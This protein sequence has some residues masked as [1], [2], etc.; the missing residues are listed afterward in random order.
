MK[1]CSCGCKGLVPVEMLLE[2]CQ[3]K[4]K[5]LDGLSKEATLCEDHCYEILMDSQWAT[6]WEN[7]TEFLFGEVTEHY[8]DPVPGRGYKTRQKAAQIIYST[9]ITALS[10][11]C[12]ICNG[13][14]ESEGMKIES[15]PEP[16]KGLNQK[17]FDLY[18]PKSVQ[19]DY[20]NIICPKCA[21]K[22]LKKVPQGVL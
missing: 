11:M 10:L 5:I 8:H 2:H 9:G 19:A 1:P 14:N 21:R 17:Y 18:L 6:G 4:T 13:L 22:A 20:G 3:G 12:P 15:L 7:R 16:L